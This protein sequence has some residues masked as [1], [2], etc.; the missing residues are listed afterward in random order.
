[1]QSSSSSLQENVLAIHALSNILQS[2]LGPQAHSKLIVDSHG[3]VVVSQDGATILRQLQVTQ[4]AVKLLVD[5]VLTLDEMIGDGTTTTTILASSLMYVYY[6]KLI[7]SIC[8]INCSQKAYDRISR[9]NININHV[10][11]GYRKALKYILDNMHT[12]THHAD[13]STSNDIVYILVE[14]S[15]SSKL[16]LHMNNHTIIQLVTDAMKHL[17]QNDNQIVQY[18]LHVQSMIGN[19]VEQSVLYRNSVLIHS[20]QILTKFDTVDNDS[21]FKVLFFNGSLHRQRSR[22]KHVALLQSTEQLQSFSVDEENQLKLLADIVVKSGC[23]ILLVTGEVHRVVLHYLQQAEVITISLNSS[24]DD[25]NN[26][27]CDTLSCHMVYGINEVNSE[28]LGRVD[29]IKYNDG[30][31]YLRNKSADTPTSLLV[32]R[33]S[34]Q[35]QCD[36]IIRHVNDAVQTVI[37][38]FQQQYSNEST[39]LVYG[40]GAFEIQCIL[41][42]KKYLKSLDEHSWIVIQGIEA[43]I[44]ALQI[45]PSILCDNNALN[46]NDTMNMLF[47]L[48]E[49]GDI[50]IGVPNPFSTTTTNTAAVFDS[51]LTKKAVLKTS[52]DL[53]IQILSSKYPLYIYQ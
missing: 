36:E 9:D 29:Q 49:Q 45:I 5:G 19:N 4:P 21:I 32:I 40:A 1:M 41:L 23:N 11:M 31:L 24:N 27:I 34:T 7:D 3:H 20:S 46:I 42:L 10:V 14:S 13:Q 22:M 48:H 38:S 28:C 51:L 44:D 53:A 50:T 47:E 39:M 17:I 26:Y 2:S 37:H 8:N 12:I 35:T 30:I 18:R 52:T 16:T 6:S 33:G 43:F 15:L 25:Y